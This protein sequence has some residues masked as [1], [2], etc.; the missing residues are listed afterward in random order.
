L[1]VPFGRI[2]YIKDSLALNSKKIK[3]IFSTKP[4]R[5]RV[6][7]MSE[8]GSTHRRM[9]GEGLISAV[10]AGL[11]FVLVG[12]IVVINQNLWS[13]IVE[14]VNSFTTAR[15]ANISVNLP[16]PSSPAAYTA[17]YSA[18]FQ[19]ALGIGALQILVLTMRLSIGSPIRRTAQNVGS[20]VFW[21]GTAYALCNLADMKSTLALSQQRDMWFQF[22]A[23]II[24]LIGLSLM[25][26]AAVLLVAGRHRVEPGKWD[27]Q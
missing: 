9:V 23:V 15:V 13:K 8:K 2:K 25:V 11:F 10:S 16:V 22:W 17:V 27:K 1:Y 18:A 19:F 14:F 21:F 12:I 5:N 4:D 6:K 24:I 7:E 26:R 3:V 20:S